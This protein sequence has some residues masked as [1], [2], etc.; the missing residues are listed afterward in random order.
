[1]DRT[2]FSLENGYQFMDIDLSS[3]MIK[4]GHYTE[5]AKDL[6]LYKIYF[7]N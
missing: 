6:A 7:A 3:F 4:N 2:T 1:M 5:M